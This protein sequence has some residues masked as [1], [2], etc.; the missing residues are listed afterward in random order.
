MRITKY[1]H[2]CVVLEKEGRRLVIDPGSFTT[3]L[4]DLHDVD[5]IVITHEHPDH[6][7]AEHLTRILEL[8]AGAP[9]FSTAVV[10]EQA[11]GFDVTVVAPG[12]TAQAGPFSLAF[13]GGDHAIIHSSIPQIRNVAV[14]VDDGEFYYAGDSFSVPEGLEVD[15]LATPASAPWLKVGEI[16]DYV[17]AVKPRHTFPTHEA[18]NSVA[19]NGMANSRIQW[20]VEQGGGQHHPLQ[21]G[22][23]FDV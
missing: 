22:E 15:V 11:E 1:E 17:L 4:F 16:I 21:P 6:W 10:A 9:I 20:A 7:T 23:S 8:N 19:G 5:G 13:S 3:P 14:S 2:A 12:D 18:I